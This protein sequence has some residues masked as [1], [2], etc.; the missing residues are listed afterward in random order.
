MAL[1]K[2]EIVAASD[3]KTEEVPVPEWGGSVAIRQLTALERDAFEQGMV[4][5]RPD[6]TREADISNMRARLCSYCIVD[7]VTGDR[8]FGD[9]ELGELG[10]K[11]GTALDRVFIAAQRLNAMGANALKETEKN[12]EGALSASSTSA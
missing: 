5:V 2:A 7:A 9:A 3:I 12:S 11:N 8:L 4:K 1:S 6:G 10:N